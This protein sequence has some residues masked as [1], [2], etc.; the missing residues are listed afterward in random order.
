MSPGPMSTLFQWSMSSL[1]HA[2]QGVRGE[3]GRG[4][5]GRGMITHTTS[6][7]THGVR[8]WVGRTCE[9]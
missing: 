1:S 4:E 2:A 3:R 9:Y 8:V 6:R 7:Q 5:R